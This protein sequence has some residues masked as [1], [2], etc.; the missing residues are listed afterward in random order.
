[1]KL[2]LNIEFWYFP[3]LRINGRILS[4]C[5]AAKQTSDPREP[6]NADVQWYHV[7]TPLLFSVYHEVFQVWSYGK[8]RS[9][10]DSTGIKAPDARVRL[11]KSCVS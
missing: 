5:Q 1:V 7:R 3:R 6:R 8:L 10:N 11:V 2:S 4:K 9:V